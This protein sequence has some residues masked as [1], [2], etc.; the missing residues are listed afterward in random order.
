[1]ASFMPAVDPTLDIVLERL[2]EVPPALLLQVPVFTCI[3]TVTPEGTGTRSRAHVMH[4]DAA[5][6][7]AHE[8]MGLHAGWGAALDPLVAYAPAI[9]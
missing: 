6:E 8:A 9:A 3:L 5:G 7:A 1:M 2:V 4:R